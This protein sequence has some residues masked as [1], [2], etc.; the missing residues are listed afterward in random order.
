MVASSARAEAR[1]ASGADLAG[2]AHYEL[3]YARALPAP[4]T[5]STTS[6]ASPRTS[7]KASRRC[8]LDGAPASRTTA[9]GCWTRGSS[10]TTGGWSR[11]EMEYR[12]LHPSTRAEVDPPPGPRRRR[13]AAGRPVVTYGVFRDITESKRADDE[14]ADLSR[15]LIRAQEEERAL[16]A[17]E[18]HDDVTQRLAVLAIDVGR[19][20]LAAANGAQA[21]TMRALREGLVRISEDVHSLAYQLHPSVLEELGLVEALRAACERLG[22]RS[23]VE[24]SLDLDPIARRS[25]EGCG[26]LPLP[27]GAG[28]AEQRGPPRPGAHRQRRPPA[29]GRRRPARR[30]R[31]RR[32]LRS[33]AVRQ[34]EG[35]SAWRACASA[36]GW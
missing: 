13:D 19:A 20:E 16:I 25:R 11:L 8:A 15:R 22:A 24:V 17:R 6:A 27:R 18:L 10:C 31:R 2:L 21:E 35:A 1:L 12:Y 29:G 7:D 14:L 23:R 26:A 32:R 34:R 28:G 36:C 9:P 33:R 4:T 30:P 3:D 5:A